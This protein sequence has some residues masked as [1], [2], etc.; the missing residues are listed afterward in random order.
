MAEKVGT[1]W[2]KQT[3]LE[4][5]HDWERDSTGTILGDQS[6]IYVNRKFYMFYQVGSGGV[7]SLVCAQSDDGINW[8]A[9][10]RVKIHDVA[11]FPDSHPNGPYHVTVKYLNN[12]FY[13]FG[14]LPK[15]D[16]SKQGIWRATSRIG[17]IKL[18]NFQ[19][20]L[21]EMDWLKPSDPAKQ[22]SH[23]LGLFGCDIVYTDK[24][25]IY[26]NTV[27]R[28]PDGTNNVSSIGYAELKNI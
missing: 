27:N 22:K 9:E 18:E 5:A 3:V 16:L 11:G 2:K 21:P 6:V 8:P 7:T 24:W 13:F 15:T 10:N 20:V 12:H 23:E 19:L 26:F 25:Y 14:W 4:A 1:E 17:E 28:T